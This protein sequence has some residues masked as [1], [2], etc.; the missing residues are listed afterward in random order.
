MEQI[1]TIVQSYNG[2]IVG[3]NGYGMAMEGL[4][5]AAIALNALR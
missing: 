2:K 1:Q 3:F 5:T 4:Q